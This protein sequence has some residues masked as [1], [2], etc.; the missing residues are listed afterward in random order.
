[1]STHR[2][3][4]IDFFCVTHQRQRNHTLLTDLLAGAAAG[5]TQDIELVAGEPERYQFRS[6]VSVN[7]HALFKAVFGRCRFDAL[8]QGDVHGQ[9]EDVTLRP[10]YGLVDKNHLLFVPRQ[11][12]V[13]WQRHGSSSHHSRMQEYLN[14]TLGGDVM[15]EPIL[16]PDAYQRLMS[17]GDLKSFELSLAR[18]RDAG[19]Y[20]HL[21]AEDAFRLVGDRNAINVKVKISV[22]RTRLSLPNWMKG[23]LQQWSTTGDARVAKATLHGT[24]EPIDLLADRLVHSASIPLQAGNRAHPDDIYAALERA[25]DEHRESLRRY[26]GA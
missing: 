23:A 18:P 12:L 21:L 3:F 11:N 14:R 6:I 15:L 1:M 25:R 7:R 9:E 13:V 20:S 2:T 16:M 5:C 10:G 8:T 24:S 22:G 26:F 19:L 17:G 4:K